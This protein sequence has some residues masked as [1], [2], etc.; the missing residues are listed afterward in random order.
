[1]ADSELVPDVDVN[2]L[3]SLLKTV[4]QGDLL[5]IPK[6]T[7]LWSPDAPSHPTE[8][9]GVEHEEPVMT[10][11]MR[12][13]V[14]LCVI[15]SQD[16]DIRLLPDIEPYI[17]V[18][19]VHEASNDEYKVASEGMSVRFFAYPEIEGHEGTQLVVDGRMIQSIEKTALLS[20][21]IKRI[22]C[23]HTEPSRVKLRGWLG[24]RLG[25]D[26]FPDEIVRR[27][28]EPVEQALKRARKQDVENVF[29]SVIW[30]GLRWTSG[31]SYCSLLL[32]TDP[33]LREKHNVG[34]PQLDLM[35]KRL[36]KALAHFTAKAGGEYT[37]QANVHD[38]TE[39]DASQ[40]LEC[41]ELYPDLEA[42]EV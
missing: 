12:L 19:P 36:R 33:A 39:V 11:E 15:V 28:I 21:H 23:P 16:C 6:M 30:T 4:R 34:E 17:L 8:V 31:K 10:A 35:I 25:R 14:P 3:R 2:E 42:V 9:E 20:S 41:Y 7:F 40:M 1:V 24:R 38:A 22:P 27:V 13:S 5:D 37:V 29:P 26:A 32:L 18:C